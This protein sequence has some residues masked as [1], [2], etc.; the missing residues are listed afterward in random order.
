MGLHYRLREG[1]TESG[2]LHR[3]GTG[4]ATPIEPLEDPRDLV[5]LDPLSAIPHLERDAAVAPLRA[6]RDRMVG[7]AVLRGVVEE[8]INRSHQTPPIG[9]DAREVG[10]DFE[11]HFPG[12]GAV[13]G[14]HVDGFLGYVPR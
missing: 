7:S 10:P 13:R 5:L 12:R 2:S 4:R 14:E 6:H 1:Q 11:G 8:V 3:G 9:F